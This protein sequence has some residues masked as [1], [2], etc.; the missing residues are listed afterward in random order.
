M[1]RVL[2]HLKKPLSFLAIFFLLTSLA[3]AEDRR[4]DKTVLVIMSFNAEFLWDGVDPEEGNPQ[5]QFDW[6]GDQ[7]EAEDH[8]RKVAEVIIRAN[9][10]I[11]NMVE[12]ENLQAL[13][14]FNDKFLAG[15]GY[16][17]YLINGTDTFTGQ[18][19]G[20]LTRIDPDSPLERDDRPGRSGSV[21]KSVSKN[22]FAKLTVNGTKIALIG[23]H[24]LA[25][26][27]SQSR[28]LER[29][30]QADAM[31]NLAVELAG[32]GFQLVMLGDFNDYDGHFNSTTQ[33]D[34]RD[35]IN[36]TPIS[37]VLKIARGLNPTT[38]TDDLI[39]ACR[40]VPKPIRFTSFFDSNNN[41]VIDGA[42]EFTSID[43]V[44]LSKGLAAKVSTVDMPHDHDPRFVSDHFPVVVH[45]RMSDAPAPTPTVAV[46]ITSLL[47]N[48]EGNEN[49]N[50]KATIKNVGTQAVSLTGWKL[51]D[52]AGQVWRL[53]ELGT[54]Q[55]G[56]E[57]EIRR[58]GQPMAM[59]NGGDTI[60]LLNPTGQAVQTVTYPRVNEGEV[61]RP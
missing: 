5:V 6:K 23:L 59:N 53:D 7:T 46:K 33:E 60:E 41:E 56:E 26:P 20:L 22:Y 25:I 34:D 57:K 1:L 47:P 48:P 21:T 52:L 24:F 44:L 31:K 40:F 8:M 15:R 16:K 18:D 39:N 11:I 32:Q 19:V 50:E 35:H 43:H 54:L 13:T 10:D 36:S 27:S 30:A 14:T 49:Q 51:R 17:P 12:V 4:I 9:P 29:E 28:R 3:W 58:K 61:V 37:N 2:A 42:N 38:D 55:P 45:L